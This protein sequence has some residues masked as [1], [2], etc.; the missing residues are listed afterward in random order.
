MLDTRLFVSKKKQTK[1][2]KEEVERSRYKQEE[3]NRFVRLVYR[4]LAS[5]IISISKA[6][7]L[8]NIPVNAIRNQLNLV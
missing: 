1:R 2:F 4:A 5:E 3:S 7:S 6:G 8:L